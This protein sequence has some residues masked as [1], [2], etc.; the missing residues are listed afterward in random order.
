MTRHTGHSGK[1]TLSIRI[2]W[3]VFLKVEIF[4]QVIHQE[5]VIA[6]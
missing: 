3:T 6:M 4:R 2:C 5:L 1:E